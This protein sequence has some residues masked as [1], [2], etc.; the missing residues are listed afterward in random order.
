MS[1]LVANMVVYIGIELQLCTPETCIMSLT[2]I[3]SIKKE[4]NSEKEIIRIHYNEKKKVEI[5]GK[6]VR[7]KVFSLSK[8]VP[9]PC[10]SDHTKS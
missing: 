8:Q 6:S 2:N 5:I 3:T 9:G 7:L 10:K 4:K 1:L